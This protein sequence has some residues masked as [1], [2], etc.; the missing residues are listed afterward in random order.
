MLNFRRVALGVKVDWAYSPGEVKILVSNDGANFDEAQCW[1]SSTRAEV[2]FEQTFMLD[3]PTNVKA[4][5]I[6]MRTPQSW[7]YF[8][9]NSV[10]LITEPGPLMLLR[11]GG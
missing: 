4:V 2:A 5:T 9:I 8:G 11:C 1:Q 3:A 6:A 10:A 7:G